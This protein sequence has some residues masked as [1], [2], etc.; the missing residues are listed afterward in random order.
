MFFVFRPKVDN[1]VARLGGWVVTNGIR[2]ETQL[3]VWCRSHTG[4]C[5]PLRG[6]DWDD[7][8]PRYKTPEVGRP[9]WT[10]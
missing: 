10:R 1:I 7:L 9:I 8:E 4:T 6:V 2:A 3:E 5:G